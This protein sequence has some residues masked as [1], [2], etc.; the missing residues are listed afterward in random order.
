MNEKDNKHKEPRWY[1]RGIGVFCG[2]FLG[3]CFAAILGVLIGNLA[4]LN[5]VMLLAAGL[6]FGV[7]IGYIFP[8]ATETFWWILSIFS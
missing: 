3:F 7:L 8:R 1:N 4:T 6:V 5:V 2:G